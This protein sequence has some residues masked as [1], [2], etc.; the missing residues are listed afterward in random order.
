LELGTTSVARAGG[1]QRA[2]QQEVSWARFTLAAAAACIAVVIYVVW[3]GFQIGGSAATLAFDDVGEAVAAVLA[4]ISCG[5]AARQS[6][7]RLRLAWIL[8]AASAASWGVGEVVWSVYEVGFNIPVPFPSP[9]DIGFLAAIPLAIAGVLAFSSAPRG[10]STSVRLWLDAGIIGLS[11][12]FAAWSVGLRQIDLGDQLASRAI[13]LAYPV[14]DI[15]IATVVVLA[16]RRATQEAYG[17]LL[18]LLGGLVA[19]AVADSAFAY[20]TASGDYGLLGSELD[21]GWVIGYLMIALAALWPGTSRLTSS[22]DSPVSLWQVAFPW[23]AVLVAGISALF[24]AISGNHFDRFLTVLAGALALLLMLTQVLA[25]RE[26][27]S[28]LITA[29]R[30]AVT[31]N[32]VIVYAPLG[33]ARLSNDLTIRQANPR[34]AAMLLATDGELVGTRVDRYFDGTAIA[35]G[36]D[37]LR[38]S[39]A[40]LLD[41]V[42]ADVKTKMGDQRQAWLHMS[43]TAVRQPDGNIDYFIAMFEDTTARHEAEAAAIASLATLERLNKVK[44]DFLTRVRHEF[45]TALVGIQGFSELMRNEESLDM[46]DARAFASDIYHDAIRLD[47]VFDEM[48]ELDRPADAAEPR[49]GG[50]RTQ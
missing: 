5:Y 46:T 25:H 28:L 33:V 26:S 15:L 16:I 34:F 32:D 24:L 42:E 47:K 44:T 39:P 49:D 50:S 6:I 14:G 7:K 40:E 48:L 8:L 20:L 18:L 30:S 3:T 37:R 22:P 19:N 12:L 11:L 10:T 43:A 41:A 27:R 13:A 23:L 36:L 9:A 17:R 31:L 21:A 4:A 38:E 29:R 1:A 35:D 45:R 2:P